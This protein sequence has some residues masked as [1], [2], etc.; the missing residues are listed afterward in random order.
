MPAELA[1]LMAGRPAQEVLGTGAVSGG[2]DAVRMLSQVQSGQTPLADSMV[3]RTLEDVERIR[4][5]PVDPAVDTGLNRAFRVTLPS[6]G[7]LYDG[8]LPGGVIE[9]TPLTL[10]DEAK[11]Y[12]QGT[13]ALDKLDSIIRAHVKSPIEPDDLLITD[14]FFILLNLRIR[15]HGGAYR[16]NGRCQFCN[17]QF[18]HEIN[19]AREIETF[20]LED[21]F[22][23]PFEFTL[24]STRRRIGL[25]FLR[26][27]DEREVAR[28]ARRM[29]LKSTDA[30]DPSFIERLKAMIVTVDGE[31]L[32]AAAK[33]HFVTNMDMGDSIQLQ[34]HIDDQECGPDLKLV[35]PCPGCGADNEMAMP[36]T[37]DFFR[38]TSRKRG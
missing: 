14:R 22:T 38:P 37:A 19:V 12:D 11:L 18:T 7:L 6:R 20:Y 5:R 17:Q 15:S 36:F 31:E 21:G 8:K 4:V 29:K 30:G 33:N 23:E 16:I 28:V 3:A 32:T 2:R 24:P 26:G 27:S 35:I 25:R 34:N 9:L 10:A 1:Q 13:Q